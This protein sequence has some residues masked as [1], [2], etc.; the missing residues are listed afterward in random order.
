MPKKAERRGDILVTLLVRTLILYLLLLLTMRLM[1]KRQIGELEVTELVTTLLISE[2]ASLPL[3]NE[4]IPLLHAVVP[5][6]IL[7]ILE[8][9]SSWLLF[10]FPRLKPVLSASPTFLI[11]SG[12][13]QQHSLLGNR[14]SVEELMTEI[15]QQG[16]PD[17][18]QVADAILEKNGKLTILPKPPFAAPTASQLGVTASGEPLSHV[19]YCSGQINRT[20]LEL[21]GRDPAWL[22]RE[23]SRRGI[24]ASSLFCVTAN[25][26][27]K[28]TLIRK[29]TGS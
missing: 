8:I 26:S 4:D 20:G 1:G 14:I 10:R 27:G 16:Y 11:R 22:R 9:L 7:L 17:M 5:I 2:I 13:L 18:D 15:R 12:V 21:I 19:V 28:L 24:V 25:R 29:E 3:T 6:L 23:L